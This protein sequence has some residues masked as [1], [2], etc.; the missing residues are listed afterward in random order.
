MITKTDALPRVTL[1][2]LLVVQAALVIPLFSHLPSWI[3]VMWA[4]VALWR[5]QRFARGQ[6]SPGGA[7]KTLLAVGCGVGL[8]TSFAGKLSTEAM[9]GL[10]V[11]AFCLKLIEVDTKRDARLL[12]MIG[13]IIGAAQLLFQQGLLA[14]LYCLLTLIG[15]VGVWCQLS[16]NESRQVW[17][18]VSQGGRLILQA[19]PIMLVL[20]VVMPRLGPLWAVP[21]QT[22]AKTG[23][24]DT[25][26]PGDLAQLA[27]DQSPAFRVEFTEAPP[28]VNQLYWRGL[29]LDEF[30]GRTWRVHPQW[31]FRTPTTRA[32]ASPDALTRYH[33][34]LEPHGQP[35]LF[36]L[37]DPQ[38][39]LATDD[40]FIT[41]DKLLLYP[42]PVT[43][44]LRYEVQSHVAKTHRSSLRLS[45]HEQRFYT[46]LPPQSNPQAVQLGRT[47]QRNG[48]STQQTIDT[49]LRLFHQEFSYTLQPPALGEHSVD[50]FLFSTKRGFCEHFS[51]A[52]VVLLRAAG[53]PS[54]V[55]VG[56]QGGQWNSVENYTL[57]R[58]SNAHAWV[59]AWTDEGWIL[60]DPTAAVAPNRI[61]QGINHALDAQD[62]AL[63]SRFWQ[64]SKTLSALQMYMDATTY[65]WQRWVLNYDTDTQDGLL[66]RLLGGT[67]T[68]R[69]TTFVSALGVIAAL[70][71]GWLMLRRQRPPEQSEELM[72]LALLEKKL[73][74]RGL[75]RRQGET[76]AHFLRRV[77]QLD[78]AATQVKDINALFEA[79]SYGGDRSQLTA[80]KNAVAAF[81]TH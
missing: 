30:N 70:L 65:A 56:Y 67:D 63:V 49:A 20:F 12:V 40:I 23:F 79:V 25:L 48:L 77:Q 60:V 69:I 37:I 76:V 43:Q 8:Y 9:I 74:A 1:L 32:T 78:P 29:V 61:E 2:W 4:G 36:S 17:E 64:R 57:V 21:T 45:H 72:A 38:R 19:I 55:V 68:W 22:I 51:S 5:L 7:L 16:A 31:Q 44:R 6:T 80:L 27:Q 53:I 3:W 75:R 54:R 35:W 71:F 14:S 18:R 13:F 66:T 50:E 62:Q 24:S 28:D 39:A 34:I 15:L 11:C 26:S 41:A 33:V 52:L 46:A 81:P 59:E 42:M 58:Q 10:L 73:R 47:W